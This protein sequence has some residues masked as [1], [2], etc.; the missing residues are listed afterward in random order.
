MK[1]LVGIAKLAAVLAILVISGCGDVSFLLP[2]ED[3]Q[4]EVLIMSVSKGAVLMPEDTFEV[5]VDYNDEE[6]FPDRMVID[7]HDRDGEV[8]FSV[9]LDSEGIFELPLPVAL[10]PDLEAGTYE[11][12]VTVFQEEEEIASSNSI[13]FF[14]KEEYQI[15]AITAYPQIFYPGGRG[16]IIA[17]LDIPDNANPYLRWSSDEVEIY[18]GLFDGGA[19]RLQLDV[20]ESE[21]VYSIRLEVF[22]FEPGGDF[23]G[24]QEGLSE[25]KEISP[26]F[27]FSSFISL[28]AQ[29]FVSSTQGVDEGELGP[30]K[31]YHSLFHFRGESIDWGS[32][33]DGAAAVP[34]GTPV[35]D[36]SRGIFGFRF[37]GNDGFA[38]DEVLL[39]VVDQYIQPFSYSARFVIDAFDGSVTEMTDG[40]GESVFSMGFA[41]GILAASLL[42]TSSQIEP[43]L[44]AGD[45]ADLTLT[46]LPEDE[47]IR[48]LWFIDGALVGD[49]LVPYEPAQIAPGGRTVIGGNDGMYGI[50]DELGVYYR[51]TDAGAEVDMEVFA[52]A[53]ERAYGSDLVLAEGFDGTELPDDIVFAGEDETY[54]IDGGSL[55]LPA[56]AIIELSAMPDELESLLIEIALLPA[57]G[58]DGEVTDGVTDG[59]TAPATLVLKNKSD[60]SVLAEITGDSGQVSEDGVLSLFV[61]S[62]DF[63]NSEVSVFIENRNENGGLEIGS[64]LVLKNQVQPSIVND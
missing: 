13:F 59:E 27:D 40:A 9:E 18:S 21:G 16:L 62:V 61:E 50:L 35:L 57:G 39:P 51:L 53:M 29:F 4:P 24:S 3:G 2:V 47:T 32:N 25:E 36:I 15:R 19:D 8:L 17:N 45:G 6:F 54:S 56:G 20:P 55:F 30:E 23:G 44:I 60:G 49:D 33:G 58:E 64:V 12:G 28:E 43:V 48:Y 5:A 7:L 38:V 52:R 1:Y 63:A 22:P 26:G 34:V 37:D 11:V 14:V 10:P 46:I 41:D 42:G 31:D